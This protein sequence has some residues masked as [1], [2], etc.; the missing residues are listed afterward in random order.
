MVP[1]VPPTWCTLQI[2]GLQVGVLAVS[3]CCLNSFTS[4]SSTIGRFAVKL[5]QQAL[6]VHRHQVVQM[7]YVRI[8]FEHDPIPTQNK[9]KHWSVLIVWVTYHLELCVAMTFY[10]TKIWYWVPYGILCHYANFPEDV[11]YE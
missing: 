4:I 5:L 2:K 8:A 1:Q 7:L 3:Q 11:S 6:C 10:N 9:C